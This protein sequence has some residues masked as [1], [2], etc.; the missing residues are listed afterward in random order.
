MERK[1][2]HPEIV[3]EFPGASV[4]R[5]QQPVVS[6]LRSPWP[7]KFLEVI[8]TVQ[9]DLLLVSPFIKNRPVDQI[10]SHLQRRGVDQAMRMTV[11]TNI[12][13]E[14]I[15][16]GSMDL[17][18]LVHLSKGVPHFK[19][20]HMPRL[21]AKVYV[22]DDRMAIV[23]S[24]NLTEP[25]ISGNLEYGTA[26]TDM[27]TVLQIRADFENYSLLGAE[28]SPND[29]AALLRETKEL[30][31][32]F[33][34]AL[35]SIKKEARRAFRRKLQATRDELLRYRAKGKTTQALLCQTILFLLAKRPLTT[36]ELQPLIQQ[37]QPDLCDDSID[38]VI[39]GVH[40]GKKWKHH[41]RSAQQALKSAGRIFYDGERW[42][43]AN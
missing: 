31:A 41:V 10:I 32:F 26:F 27:Q 8:T 1:R 12:R 28:V 18:A 30:K 3:Q 19:L 38:R 37:L 43:L 35:H 7:D 33:R 11:L 17:E 29:V 16:N 25:G 5:P 39:A 36:A 34:Q 15:L 2:I 24:A 21:H 20:T 22:A 4:T 23:T 13:P 42:H 40:F 14:S 6:L 9:S